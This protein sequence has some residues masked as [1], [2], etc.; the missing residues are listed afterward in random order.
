MPPASERVTGLVVKEK[1]KGLLRSIDR[2]IRPEMISALR[3]FVP[4][5]VEARLMAGQSVSSRNG[6]WGAGRLWRLSNTE[7]SRHKGLDGRYY[8][9]NSCGE[10]SVSRL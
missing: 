4:H 1:T 8:G 6:D 7:G 5:S 3:A 9:S 10:A 2:L